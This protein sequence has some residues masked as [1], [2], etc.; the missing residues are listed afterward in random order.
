MEAPEFILLVATAVGALTD[1]KSGRIPNALTYPLWVF[2]GIYALAGGGRDALLDSLSGFALA[3]VPCFLL[4]LSGGLGGGDVKMMAA[5]GALM[6]FH[7][8]A[9][10]MLT[11]I[12]VGAAIAVLIVIWEGRIVTTL[13]YLGWRLFG[14]GRG[15]SFETEAPA[16]VPFGVAICLA[17]VLTLIESWHDGLSFLEVMTGWMG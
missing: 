7:F 14:W 13:K 8:T 5:V 9:S 17:C 6:G 10:A 16:Q 11:S 4:Y 1:I 15:T 2:G 3:F 12:F